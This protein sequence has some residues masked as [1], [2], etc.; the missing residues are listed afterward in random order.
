MIASKEIAEISV[1]RVRFW[2]FFFFFFFLG[3]GGLKGKKPMQ[4]FLAASLI[5]KMRS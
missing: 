2:T 5:Q 4:Y 1:G 3:G